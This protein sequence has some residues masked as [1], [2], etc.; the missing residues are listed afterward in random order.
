MQPFLLTYPEGCGKME[1]M[2]KLLDRINSPDDLKDL[3]ISQLQFLTEE[4]REFIIETVAATGGHLASSLGVVELTI[5]LHYLFDSPTDKTIW[6]V[7]HQSYVHKLLTGR[8]DKFHTLRQSGGISGFPKRNESEHDCFGTGHASTSIS[9]AL[10][11]ACARDLQHKDYKVIAVIGD[12]SLSGGMAFEALNHIGHL[13][14]DILVILNSNEM[15]ISPSVGAL[16]SYLN[17][18]LTMPA[19]NRIREDFDYLLSKVPKLGERMKDL[20]KRLEE[21]VKNLLVP[22]AFFEEL[23]LR[24]FGPFDGHNLPLLV[25]TMGKIKAMKGPRLIHVVTKKGKGYPLA[26]E[27]PG[28]FHGASPFEVK[29][30]KPIKISPRPTYSEIFGETI[31]ELAREDKRIVAITAAMCDGTGLTYFA[32]EFKERLFDVGIA[33]EH[34][35]T[36]ASGMACQGLRPVVAVYSTF[37]QRAYDQIVHDVCLQNLP[38]I[39]AID[40]GGLVGEDG[41]THHGLFDLSYLRHLPNMILMAPRNGAEL[42]A[43]LRK[44][45]KL[46]SPVAIRYPRG[47]IDEEETGKLLEIELGKAEVLRKGGDGAIIACGTMAKEAVSA[48]HL[49]SKEG[50]KVTVVNARFVKPLDEELILDLAKETG[51]IVTCEENVRAGGFGSAVS[52][53]LA[54]KGINCPVTSIGIKDEFVSQ[55]KIAELKE[56]HGLT[57]LRIAKALKEL[58]RRDEESRN[59]P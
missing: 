43:M 47:Q 30:G 17:R 11:M 7:G 33:E 59:N 34:A 52:E 50:I 42:K 24:Y 57:A 51:I 26:E 46:S 13:K 29:T 15:S 28:W 45:V 21:G 25:E 31:C 54:D 9:A 49:L 27:N 2:G 23:G 38:V 14:K 48:F 40:R 35:V 55:G 16:S 56:E 18:L 39:F 32:H 1:D 6:D 41:P 5:A 22:G 58:R 12:G 4:I 19:Y 20:A 3:T 37:L 53:L 44:A 10:G 36:L 8:R